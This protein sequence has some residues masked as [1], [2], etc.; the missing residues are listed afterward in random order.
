MKSIYRQFKHPTGVVGALVGH[1]MAVKNRARG[2]WVTSLLDLA[3]GDRALEV[4]FGPGA[5]ARRVLRAIGER[6]T[7]LGVDASEVMVRQARERNSDSVASGRARFVFGELERGLPARDGAHDV[8][9]A[10]NCAQFWT[11]LAGGLAEMARTLAPGGRLVVAVQPR[12]ANAS[13]ADSARWAERLA[14]AAREAGLADVT[15]AMG[16]TTPPV[17][18]V[19]ARRR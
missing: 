12:N 13:A 9:F 5:D 2:E 19:R 10:I 18:A 4:G 15:V 17:A 11:D 14:A 6:G 1:A 7:Y 3:P 16:P 8:V